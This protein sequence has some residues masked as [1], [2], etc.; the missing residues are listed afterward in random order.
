M[1]VQTIAIQMPQLLY[2]RLERLAELTRRPLENLV[3]QTLDASVPSLPGDLPQEMRGDLQALESLDD[4]SLW[5]VARSVVGLE[6]RAQHSLLLEK[7][8][9]GP[10]TELERETLAQLCQKADLLMLRKAYAYVLLKWRGHRLPTLAELEA[11]GRDHAA[12]QRVCGGSRRVG[13][14]QLNDVWLIRFYRLTYDAGRFFV[15]WFCGLC[16][17]AVHHFSS[18]ACRLERGVTGRRA[19]AVPARRDVVRAGDGGGGQRYGP[20][21]QQRGDYGRNQRKARN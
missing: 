3:V 5:Q 16:V 15:G 12:Q 2:H 20:G 13:I 9:Q 17:S 18:P 6:Q 11:Q 8:R 4:E 19:V 21:E 10:I 7:N 14:R 1:S